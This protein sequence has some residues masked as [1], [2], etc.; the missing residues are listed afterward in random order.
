MDKD[1]SS[2]KLVDLIGCPDCGKSYLQKNI[3]RHLW[4]QHNWTRDE[5]RNLVQLIR[6]EKRVLNERSTYSCRWCGSAYKS[7]Q[8][9]IKHQS[10]CLINVENDEPGKEQTLQKPMPELRGKV[11]AG[12]HSNRYRSSYTV[13]PEPSC[14]VKLQVDSSDELVNHCAEFHSSDTRKFEIERQIFQ[15]YDAF[16]KWFDQR[17]ED[18]CTS[19]TKRTGH[20]GETLYRCHMIGKYSSVAKKRKSNPRKIDQSCTAFLKVYTYKDGTTYASGCFQHIGHELNHKLLWLTET[21]ESYVKELIDRGFTSDQ[22]YHYIRQEYENYEC[23]LKY[24]SKNDIRNIAVRHKRLKEVKMEEEGEED[25]ED[26]LQED[27]EEGPSSAK[28][29]PAVDVEPAVEG[30][31]KGEDVLSESVV[32]FPT[33][34]PASEAADVKEEVEEA[35][36]EQPVVVEAADVN[37]S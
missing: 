22:I 32:E 10:K 17:Q 31:S 12:E 1:E 19:L 2:V 37:C 30:C 18:S 33:K 20:R 21:Q 4:D 35:E 28:K 25:E 8:G 9:Y 11:M 24:I 14:G 26:D 5:C 23:K 13:C 6:S 27:D 16:K 29:P 3:Y 34:E 36:S 15:T 7:T